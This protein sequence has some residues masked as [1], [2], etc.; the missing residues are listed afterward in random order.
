MAKPPMSVDLTWTEGLAFRVDAA[1][2]A[3]SVVDGRRTRGSLAGGVA[4]RR[5]GVVH[6]SRPRP[7]PDEG[8]AA[9][10]RRCASA[11]RASARRRDP[12]RFTAIRLEFTIAGRGDAS[13]GRSR[14]P[15]VARQVLLGVELAARGHHARD[16]DAH[17]RRRGALTHG[18]VQAQPCPPPRRA[19]HYLDWLRGVAVLDHDRRRTRSTP[20]RVP[21]IARAPCTTGPSSS[22]AW[23]R[24][25]SCCSRASPWPSR[26]RA[27][28][29]GARQRR[30]RRAHRPT[31]RRPDLPVRVPV[32]AP[33]VRA[34]PGRVGVVAAEGRH[35]QRDGASR[36]SVPPPVAGGARVGGRVLLL[37]GAA[38][39]AI[40]MLDPPPA[41]LAVAARAARPS[42]VVFPPG[43]G[44]DQLHAAAVERVRDRGRGGGRLLCRT[45]SGRGSS[46][47]R[48]RALARSRAAPRPPAGYAASYLPALYP[49]TNFWT[50][51]PTFFFLRAGAAAAGDLPGMGMGAALGD[52]GMES[53]RAP[54]PRV[55][56]RLLDSRRDGLR[57]ADDARSTAGCRCPGPWPALPAFTAP[58][59]RRRRHQA[60]RGGLVPEA[61]RAGRHRAE[62]AVRTALNG[63][64]ERKLSALEPL[65]A[66]EHREDAAKSHLRFG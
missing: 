32:Q 46:G 27:A 40:A 58:D 35:P 26:R 21:P 33:V 43:P 24:P 7:Y 55:A 44:P 45:P 39:A 36:S 19:P 56:V 8:A 2:A 61:A 47:M 50:S 1:M 13:A 42:R 57:P 51:S 37:F 18:M 53:A 14:R 54:R 63:S 49:Q 9:R 20:G 34:Q 41:G 29:G 59:A 15:A 25:S 65:P 10:R 16:R 30:G 48:W 52:R 12:H 64:S 6:G 17:R 23:A 38:T 5:H 22:E 4:G 62:K 3:R 11:S 28:C 60:S 66:A 31:P